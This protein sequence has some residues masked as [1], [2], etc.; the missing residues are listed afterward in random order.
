MQSALKNLA[1]MLTGIGMITGSAG[2]YVPGGG[3]TL[4]SGIDWR[5]GHK[6]AA[7]V[8]MVD[9]K[10]DEWNR[11]SQMNMFGA[12][13]MTPTVIEPIPSV[14]PPTEPTLAPASGSSKP[15]NS[16]DAP[17]SPALREANTPQQEAPPVPGPTSVEDIPSP[18]RGAEASRR[19]M[20]DRF[21]RSQNASY[22]PQSTRADLLPAVA[23]GNPQKPVLQPS[24]QDEEIEDLGPVT[25]DLPESVPQPP[26]AAPQEREA[27]DYRRLV[28]PYGTAP[29]G[30]SRTPAAN[31]AR[32]SVK[33]NRPLPQNRIQ[34]QRTPAKSSNAWLFARP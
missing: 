27:N 10:W 14:L 9:T 7:F 16:G 17:A 2:C 21:R 6:P 31:G 20:R 22:Q 4:R 5:I 26:P 33:A 18:P 25:I 24:V 15:G 11:V 13:A 3:W 1:T 12:P 28:A 32:P 19:S 8:E 30:N 29:A 23:G 34:G